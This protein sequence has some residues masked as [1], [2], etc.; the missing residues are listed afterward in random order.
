MT[1]REDLLNHLR[2]ANHLGM[3]V[4][5]PLIAHLLRSLALSS[6]PGGTKQ[7]IA[8]NLLLK[9]QLLVMTRSQKRAPKTNPW[10]R[11]LLGFLT[12][13]LSKR[14]I[15]RIGIV[16]RPSTLL[17]FHDALKCLKYRILYTARKR[18]TPGPKGPSPELIRAVVQFKGLNPRCGY[19]RIA[20]QISITFEVEIDKDMVRRILATH[21]KPVKNK[22]GPSWLT[23]L[24]HTKDSLW[25]MDLF[26]TESIVLKTHWVLVVMDQHTRR[27]VGFA[28]QPIVVDGA[29]LCRMFNEIIYQTHSPKRL[30][31]DHDPI[32]RYDQWVRNLRILDIVPIRTIPCVPLSHPFVERLIGTIRREYLDHLFFW[33]SHDLM[34]KLESFKSYYN[35]NRTH[36]G[37]LGKI[38]DKIIK[39][40]TFES[41]AWKPLC[42]GLFH[43]PV[44]A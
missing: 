16:F 40:A 6:K 3:N 37:L 34:Q 23:L 25:S 24:G 43:M 9:M 38:P 4:I 15:Q 1:F 36:Q 10:Q 11:L 44:A 20:E 31:L 17:K 27:I 13:F 14:R 22:S 21:Y 7:V 30:S 8:E 28:I 41:Y 39:P 35:K 18:R 42:K 12:L 5:F 19:R 33:N 2:I 32:F 26:K 29:A